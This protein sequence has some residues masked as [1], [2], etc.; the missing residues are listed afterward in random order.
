MATFPSFMDGWFAPNGAG[1]GAMPS[2]PGDPGLTSQVQNWLKNQA[3][4]RAAG[5]GATPAAAPVTAPVAT[6]S[7]PGM[8]S[9]AWG[10]ANKPMSAWGMAKGVGMGL[11]KG[12]TSPA[13]LALPAAG[14]VTST[15]A[16]GDPIS[17]ALRQ[18]LFTNAL[19]E[20]YARFAP[21][22]AGG[23]TKPE[24]TAGDIHGASDIEGRF[25][26]APPVSA[27]ATKPIVG[28]VTLPPVTRESVLGS[29]AGFQPNPP[30]HDL[31][32]TG[33]GFGSRTTPMGGSFSVVPSEVMMAPPG[34]TLTAGPG[35]RGAG[36]VYTPSALSA[37]RQAAADRGDWDA[38]QA[39]YQKNGGTWQGTTAAQDAKTKLMADATAAV[40]NA[41]TIPQ[42]HNAITM[43]DALQKNELMR[44]NNAAT[45][46]A[47][48]YGHDVTA[49]NKNIDTW[50]K[51][52]GPEAQKTGTEN[53]MLRARLG[54]AA[55]APDVPTA[56]SYIGAHAVP[57]P[58]ALQTPLGIQPMTQ[59]AKNPVANVFNPNTGKVVSTPVGAAPRTASVADFM[60][61]AKKN[62][63]TKTVAQIRADAARMGV[64][65]ID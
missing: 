1:P 23:L 27:A 8:L 38:V 10:A 24:V 32:S 42:Q 30:V 9:T 35:G 17:G 49:K 53:T 4:A 62:G 41:K 65:L 13:A 64:Q 40:R 55:T 45:V 6:S 60:A 15:M 57:A 46:G 5:M 58:H 36:A 22:W 34:G 28:A 29:V 11:W 21:T 56:M 3:Q 33:G 54:A 48:I 26:A 63:Q 50:L 31:A 2:A 59:D 25:D 19:G 12:L 47:T 7:G 51:L 43:L 18:D 44:E 61:S 39:S 16:G 20:G 14:A 52:N 37:A